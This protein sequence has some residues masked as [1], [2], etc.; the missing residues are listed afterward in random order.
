L[1]NVLGG[2]VLKVGRNGRIKR[3]VGHSKQGF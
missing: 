1:G 2:F 3:G